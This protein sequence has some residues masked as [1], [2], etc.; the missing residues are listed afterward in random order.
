MS[1]INLDYYSNL[2]VQ[3]SE[4]FKKY[5][6]EK[7]STEEEA[8]KELFLIYQQ[9]LDFLKD[10]EL[11]KQFDISVINTIISC[12]L[13]TEFMINEIQNSIFKKEMTLLNEKIK[14]VDMSIL[15]SKENLKEIDNIKSNLF[16]FFGIIVGVLAFVFVN[17]QLF[18]KASDLKIREMVVFLGVSNISLILGLGF[19]IN[20]LSTILGQNNIKLSNIFFW[21][22][23][24]FSIIL[25][26][27][28]K[29]LF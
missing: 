29:F 23:I 12:R 21:I 9:M 26:C 28:N 10:N 27:G 13:N 4:I 24:G 11:S 18:S 7:Y 6:E 20:T 16:G 19:F 1:E 14:E 15:S 8:L 17:F 25:I 5:K 3:T 22:S 2:V